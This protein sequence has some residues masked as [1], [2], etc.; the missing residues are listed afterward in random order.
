MW[1]W[2]TN[3]CSK[4][5]RYK[6]YVQSLKIVKWGLKKEKYMH[7]CSISWC[8]VYSGPAQWGLIPCH[9][10]LRRLQYPSWITLRTTLI[11]IILQLPATNTC[12]QPHLGGPCDC[13]PTTVFP[14]TC[15]RNTDSP[16]KTYPTNCPLTYMVSL[17]WWEYWHQ[18]NE[19]MYQRIPPCVCWYISRSRLACVAYVAS[20]TSVYYWPAS[21]LNEQAW[22]YRRALWYNCP[23]SPVV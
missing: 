17:H 11:L 23:Y 8:I 15:L 3:M 13:L 5:S 1:S 4:V 19:C 20:G 21:Y 12:I 10:P 6:M 22:A 16:G 2:D 14:L 9:T 7:S 18:T